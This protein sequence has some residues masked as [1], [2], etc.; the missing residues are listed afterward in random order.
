MPNRHRARL[1]QIIHI[2]GMGQIIFARAL[3]SSNIVSITNAAGE[4][5]R[6]I[7]PD[8]KQFACFIDWMKQADMLM[9]Q[10][11]FMIEPLCNLIRHTFAHLSYAME[12]MHLSILDKNNRI[13]QKQAAAGSLKTS[14]LRP[15]SKPINFQNERRYD[16]FRS[17]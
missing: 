7:D 14:L 1:S 2:P 13:S 15:W 8:A 12:N 4:N 6:K 17:K 5:I 10:G 3:K 9:F 16:Q 11:K